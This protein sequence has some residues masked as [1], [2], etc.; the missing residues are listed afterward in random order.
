VHLP[1]IRA[2]SALAAIGAAPLSC[3]PTVSHP[4]TSGGGLITGS[5][6]GSTGAH[7]A[8]SSTG[9]TGHVTSATSTTGTTSSGT[10]EGQGA[11]ST[12]SAGSTAAASGTSGTTSSGGWSSGTSGSSG[13]SGHHHGSSSSSSSTSAGGT[14]ATSTT[15]SSTTT[16]TTAS[17]TT[18]S[19]TASST[20]S[21]TTASSTTTGTTTSGTTASSTTT[22]TTASST[23]TGGTTTGGTTTGGTTNSGWL[24]T[25]GN[26]IYND[27]GT[28]WHARGANIADTRSCN[29]C[30]YSAP[31]VNEV[32][33]R[34][35]E[36]TDNWHAN[37]M[38]L[39]MESYASAGG[40]VTWADVLQDPSYL[41][42]I[43]T[44]VAHVEAKQNVYIMLSLWVDPTFTT[45]GWPTTATGQEWTL[46]A[47]TFKD[48][49]HVLFGLVNEPQNNYD[50]S[51]DAQVWTAMNNTVA[52]IRAAEDAAGG[53][54]H[55]VAVQGTG[56]WSRRLGYY[57]THPITAD[58]GD[59]IA[60]E[61]HVYDPQANFQSE[62]VTPAA[63]IPVI[64]GEFGPASGYMTNADCSALMTQA[65][66]LEVPYLAWTFHMR[67]DPNL[68]VDNSG[69]G[70]GVNMNLQPTAW[71]TLLKNQL[72]NPY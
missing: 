72:A 60:Y 41:N 6:S 17:S 3:G 4:S 10:T 15:A 47:Q 58:T 1:W 30:A 43:Q 66:Q 20:T 40:R 21:G 23:T 57:V 71:G 49:P 50:G 68:L 38:R 37:F 39:D 61:V 56:G 64:I 62:W 46:L 34:I 16:G 52:N 8:S 2:L 44:I 36:L 19:T 45:S 67:C 7:V 54:H 65:E 29:A 55:I 48:D 59:N 5:T 32:L 12:A 11:I 31:D 27:D 14:T 70:C 63:T 28:V 42:D 13:S 25:A 9:T 18:S 33:R 35:D 24:H 26:H 69:G 53:P 22:G 51:Q